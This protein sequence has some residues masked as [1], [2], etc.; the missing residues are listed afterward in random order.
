M[1][2]SETPFPADVLRSKNI[3]V[4]GS[5]PGAWTVEQLGEELPSLIEALVKT[6]PQNFKVVHL[7]DVESAWSDER[8]RLVFVP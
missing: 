8:D 6:E 3:T 7:K 5:G 1:A 2:T 4:R